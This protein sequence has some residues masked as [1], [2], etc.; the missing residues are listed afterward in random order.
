MKEALVSAKRCLFLLLATIALLGAGV[1]A[2]EE[3]NRQ[4]LKTWREDP[5]HA[6]RLDRDL[7]A[8]HALSRQAQERMRKLDQDLH[9]ADPKTRKHYVALLRAY[10]RWFDSLSADQQRRLTEASQAERLD[11]IREIRDEQLLSRLP[12]ARQRELLKLSPDQRHER[13][14]EIRRK[15][16]PSPPKD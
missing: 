8:F 16:S 2:D 15:K 11:L 12:E 14:L 13:L 4:L 3:H 5:K 7:R 1:S 6:D 9:E 10:R